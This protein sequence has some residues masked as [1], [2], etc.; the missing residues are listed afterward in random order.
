LVLACGASTAWAQSVPVEVPSVIQNVTVYPGVAVVERVA[1]VPARTRLLV[2]SC[3]STEFDMS[4]LRVDADAGVLLGAMSAVD[5]PRNEVPACAHSPLD[6]KI[7]ALEQRIAVQQAEH[8]SY[9]LVLNYLKKLGAEDGSSNVATHSLQA[10]LVQIQRSS[11]DASM[12]QQRLARERDALKQELQLLVDQRKRQ[13]APARVRQLRLELSTEQDSALRLSYPVP[14]ATW[15]PAYRATLDIANS[16]VQMERLA[17]VSQNSGED[18]RG[19]SLRLSTAQLRSAPQGP[20]PQRWRISKSEGVSF[21]LASVI[22]A[23]ASA[24][25][26]TRKE[27][28]AAAPEL[29]FAVQVV[30]GDYASEFQV[31]GKVDVASGQ[32]RVVFS[33]ERQNWP[34]RMLVQTTPQREA[35]A[36]LKAE[37]ARPEG[38]WPDGTLYLLRDQQAIGQSVWRMGDETQ[39]TLPFGRDPK[40]RVQV[41]S[42]PSQP[43][44]TGVFSVRTE[45]REARHY[46]VQ[47]L[48]RSPIALEVLEARPVSADAKISVEATFDPAVEPQPWQSKDGILVWRKTLPPSATATF[49]ANYLISHPQ[50]MAV[51]Y[52]L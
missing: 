30:H 26:F 47:N 3:L 49:K 20:V 38:V 12:Q 15:A 6:A 40:V 16:K 32:Q 22:P 25:A 14:V 42:Q 13:Q 33:L 36:W 31:P 24:P 34:A 27:G 18:W 43:A 50:D 48:H 21:S 11:L 35:S 8:A 1:K 17:Q 37:V 10:T 9:E 52:D 4:D 5:L 51:D 2:L 44:S 7:T 29:D 39:L 19:V 28:R 41:R 23:P 46:E 45:L